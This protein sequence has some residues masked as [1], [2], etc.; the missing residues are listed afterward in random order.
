MIAF[1]R[2]MAVATSAALSSSSSSLARKSPRLTITSSPKLFKEVFFRNR[3]S[4][5]TRLPNANIRCF[6]STASGTAPVE[7]KHKIRVQNPI[8]EMDGM[9]SIQF[10]VQILYH[11]YIV[12]SSFYFY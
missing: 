6:A 7:T 2:A 1:R 9:F 12:M 5:P 4:Y 3:L 11:I 10:T 8:V